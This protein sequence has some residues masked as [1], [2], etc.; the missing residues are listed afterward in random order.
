[1]C[2]FVIATA[3]I[4]A[5]SPSTKPPRHNNKCEK[6]KNREYRRLGNHKK[7]TVVLALAESVPTAVTKTFAVPLLQ[8]GNFN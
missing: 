3:T 8:D 7:L 6:L 1:M 4:I 2:S 5:P